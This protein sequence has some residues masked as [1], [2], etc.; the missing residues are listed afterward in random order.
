MT[1]VSPAVIFS[2]TSCCAEGALTI[3][4]KENHTGEIKINPP[5]LK[6]PPSK[7]WQIWKKIKPPLR[8]QKYCQFSD[9]EGGGFYFYLPGRDAQDF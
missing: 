8:P 6:G 4:G 9:L 7:F 3:L 1:M 5:Q 2:G